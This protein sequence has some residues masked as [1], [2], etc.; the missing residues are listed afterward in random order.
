[1]QQELA[2]KQW[3]HKY[4]YIEVPSWPCIRRKQDLANFNQFANEE[5]AKGDGKNRIIPNMYIG[6]RNKWEFQSKNLWLN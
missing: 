2:I 4:R 3:K 1:M 6:L 5:C